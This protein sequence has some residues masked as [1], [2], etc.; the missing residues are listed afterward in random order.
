MLNIY[1]NL[2]SRN[3]IVS[4]ELYCAVLLPQI[5]I[6]T[7]SKIVP[8]V[9]YSVFWTLKLLT[10]ILSHQ[11]LIPSELTLRI[12]APAWTSSLS[13]LFLSKQLHEWHNN[14]MNCECI[15]L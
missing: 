2:I 6:Q 4:V 10:I 9:G 3:I 1:L 8:Q 15:T 5:K 14:V 12:V 7:T 11:L 13:G